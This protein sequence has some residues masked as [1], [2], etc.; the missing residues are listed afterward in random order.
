MPSPT[1]RSKLRWI[2]SGSGARRLGGTASQPMIVLWG[3]Y[4]TSRESKSG[5]PTPKSCLPCQ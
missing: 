3:E 4:P 5:M 2:R 1:I